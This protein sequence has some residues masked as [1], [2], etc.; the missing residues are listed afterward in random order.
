MQAGTT[1]GLSR[2]GISFHGSTALGT[3]FLMDGVDMSFG[4]VNGSAGFA[5][6]GGSGIINTISVEAIEEFK[7]TASAASA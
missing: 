4:E 3:N 7:S 1:S 2:G 5:S 6:A